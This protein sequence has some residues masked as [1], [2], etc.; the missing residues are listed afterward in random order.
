M[1]TALPNGSKI[2]GH[3]AV[4]A[5][6][7]MPDVGHRAATRYSA[8]APGRFTPMPLVSLQRCRRPARQLRQ[9]PQTTCP[10]PLTMSPG[11]KSVHVGADLDDLADELVPDHH[12]HRDRLLR[13]GVPVVD[14]QVGAADAGAVSTWISTSLMPIV[15]LGHILEPEAGF[16]FAFD[17]C[18]HDMRAIEND[19]PRHVARGCAIMANGWSPRKNSTAAPNCAI[20]TH[21]YLGKPDLGEQRM[22]KRG[23]SESFCNG[24]K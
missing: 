12:R 7:V 17:Q 18:F 24:F 1:C 23:C 6:S 13:P 9:R 5:G 19:A 16:G 8:N 3:V 4:D 14:V 2:D 21:S 22:G 15:G 11:R 20:L 10:S